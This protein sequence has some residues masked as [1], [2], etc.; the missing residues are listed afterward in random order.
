MS[1]MNTDLASE[2]LE[3]QP[4]L[5]GVSAPG[6]ADRRIVAPPAYA[7]FEAIILVGEADARFHRIA[8]FVDVRIDQWIVLV[9][10]EIERG[11]A[12]Q[13]P[14]LEE[15]QA[16]TEAEFLMVPQILDRVADM[17]VELEIARLEIG[18]LIA[19]RRVDLVAADGET[20]PVDTETMGEAQEASVAQ[21]GA[22]DDVGG[23]SRKAR[24]RRKDA[25]PGGTRRNVRRGVEAIA[26]ADD[27]SQR[28][29]RQI[30]RIF[31]AVGDARAIF[32]AIIARKAVEREKVR[33]LQ[34]DRACIL[35]GDGE[36]ARL[37]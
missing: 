30:Q 22:P 19:E 10:G 27:R 16:T 36:V 35:V 32:P 26:L 31:E 37:G 34:I 7:E 5:D 28:E 9:A 6:V 11:R 20:L 18:L 15:R 1:S 14:A 23:P 4:E 3:R 8:I 2:V 29:V 13:R 25:E 33:I 21:R 24:P 12:K 17:A